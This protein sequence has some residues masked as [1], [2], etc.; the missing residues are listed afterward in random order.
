MGVSQGGM[1]PALH[2]GGSVEQLTPDQPACVT[3]P[4]IEIDDT[5]LRWTRANL[6]GQHG[7]TLEGGPYGSFRV[8]SPWDMR[9]LYGALYATH[10]GVEQHCDD[11]DHTLGLVLIAEGS[12]RLVVDEHSWPLEVGS[13]YHIDSDRHHGTTSEDPNGLLAFITLDFGW[14]EPV[15]SVLTYR[16]FAIDVQEAFRLFC[17]K[18]P[19]E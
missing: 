18:T 7:V 14:K 8:R 12:H 4:L 13:V 3:S 2:N 6:E 11:A 5:V 10:G 1:T 19:I 17:L 9:Q 16:D 15:P